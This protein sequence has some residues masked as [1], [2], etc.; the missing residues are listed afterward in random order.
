MKLP[1]KSVSI[2]LITINSVLHHIKDTNFFLNELHRILKKNGILIASFPNIAWYKYRMDM[3]RGHFPRNY[4]IYP[5][6]HIQNFTLHSFYKLLQE[7]GFFPIEIDGQFIFPRI[8]KPARFFAPIFKKFPNL[9]GYQIVVK[10]KKG[11][12]EEI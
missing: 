1:F 5:G 2:D 11:K 4:L 10:S 9:F 6:E 7:N 3:L 12:G 8:F